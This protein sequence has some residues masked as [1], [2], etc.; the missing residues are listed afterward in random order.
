MSHLRAI[1]ILG[2]GQLLDSNRDNNASLRWYASY[3]T[4]S[5]SQ[6]GVN[7]W[8]L[9]TLFKRPSTTALLRWFGCSHPI[10]RWASQGPSLT[11]LA[12]FSSPTRRL[13]LAENCDAAYWL[14]CTAACDFLLPLLL[15]AGDW[16]ASEFRSG[17]KLK[18]NQ[19]D[20]GGSVHPAD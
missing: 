10:G 18:T 1:F 7:H 19:L 13:R 6:S 17:R 9:F 11:L 16:G 5:D 2:L 20:T 15:P 14:Y 4:Q 3:F 12:A 8:W